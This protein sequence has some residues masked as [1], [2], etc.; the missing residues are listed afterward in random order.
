MGFMRH[1][2]L[3]I[4]KITQSTDILPNEPFRLST[5][6]EQASSFFEIIFFLDNKK[7]R[8]G[9]EADNTTVYAEWLYSDEKGKEACLFHKDIDEGKHY[10]NKERFREGLDLKTP[11]NHLFIWKCDQNN[12]VIAGKILQWF[13]RFN[14]IDGLENERYFHFALN[15]M[16]NDNTKSELLKLIKIADLGIDDV[17]IEEKDVSQDIKNLPV[18]DEI[19][20][21]LLNDNT[22]LMSIELQTRHKKYDKDKQFIGSVVFELDE[23]ES[24]GTKKF[25][26]LSAPILDTLNKGKVLLVDE[27]DASLHPKLTESLIKLFNNKELNKNNAQLIFV[28]HDVHLLSAPRLFDRDQIW[29][30]EKDQYGNTQ[31]YSLLEFRKKNKGKNVRE[32]DNLTKHYLQGR[33]GAVPYLGEW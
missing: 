4:P 30:V 23:D 20:Q 13:N 19:K 17:N 3:N 33:F 28:T 1:L 27:L 18:P 31:L 15:Q 22:G 14:L 32:T 25:F 2:V 5:E 6:T 24:Q 16:G 26:T 8:Y 9:F 29:F 10:I 21:K 7:Y 11:R 12:G